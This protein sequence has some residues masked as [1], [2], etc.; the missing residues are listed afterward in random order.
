MHKFVGLVDNPPPQSIYEHPRYRARVRKGNLVNLSSSFPCRDL[1]V[2]NCW[3]KAYFLVA[4]ISSNDRQIYSSF[5]SKLLNIYTFLR[6]NFFIPCHIMEMIKEMN[7]KKS[8]LFRR[9]QFS[10]Q[11]L[12]VFLELR[13]RKAA[14]FSEQIMSAD[15]YTS[16]FSRQMETIVY[17]YNARPWNNC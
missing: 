15:K 7:D 1:P 2:W 9:S 13:S 11:K 17:K 4:N 12:T 8:R 10:S 14:R 6:W 5:W 3:N 16:I